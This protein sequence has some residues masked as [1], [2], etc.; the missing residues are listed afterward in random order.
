[1]TEDCAFVRMH[2]STSCGERMPDPWT[3]FSGHEPPALASLQ[4]RWP[5][6]APLDGAWPWCTAVLGVAVVME[7]SAQGL[8][9]Q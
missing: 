6:D 9:R 1:M 8:T 3:L 2:E 5:D 4:E 7:L